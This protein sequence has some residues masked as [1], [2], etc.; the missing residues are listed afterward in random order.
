MPRRT[1]TAGTMWLAHAAAGLIAFLAYRFGEAAFFAAHHGRTP[2]GSPHPG[3]GAR[4]GHAQPSKCHADRRPALAPDSPSEFVCESARPPLSV[5][6]AHTIPRGLPHHSVAVRRP[7]S[8]D[9]TNEEIPVHLRY[10]AHRRRSD[11]LAAP[12]AASAHVGIDPNQSDPGTYPLITF[13][14]PTESATATTTRI[15][16]DPSAG[17]PVSAS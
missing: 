1:T 2:A 14:V 6:S 9:Y 5:Y 3:A 16:P 4:G 7:L 13:K 12:L 17:H 8:K 11:A 10:R 15:E